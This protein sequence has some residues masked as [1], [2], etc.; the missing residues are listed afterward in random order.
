MRDLEKQIADWRRT[1]RPEMQ[2]ELE[3]HLREEIQRLMRDGKSSEQAFELAVSKL[4]QPTALRAEFDKLEEMRRAQWKPATLARWACVGIAIVAAVFVVSRL[5]QGGMTLLLASHVLPITIGYLTMFI[6]GGLAT[7]YALAEWF[8]LAGP[9]QRYALRRA[10]LQLATI[11]LVLTALGISLGMIWAKQNWGRYWAWDPKENGA[12]LVLFCGAAI[13]ALRWFRSSHKTLIV[14][15]ILGSAGT[16][17]GW[18]GANDLTRFHPLLIAFIAG[19]GLV[20]AAFS[21]TSLRKRES[22]S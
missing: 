17:I 15:G 7:C 6:I 1:L 9:T 12:L 5:G 16:A 19:H 4:G 20:L 2:E 3:A 10:T 8:Q 14:M 13:T 21:L 22:L 11:S 18:F